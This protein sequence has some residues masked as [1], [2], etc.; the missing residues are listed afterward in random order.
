[1]RH[2]NPWLLPVL[3]RLDDMAYMTSKLLHWIF[4]R[5]SNQPLLPPPDH[6]KPRKKPR[7]LVHRALHKVRRKKVDQI[8]EPCPGIYEVLDFLKAH[9]IPIAMVSNGLGKGYGHDILKT[10]DLEEYFSAIIFREDISKSKPN[11]ESLSAAIKKL[12]V[13]TNADT[14]IWYIGDRRKDVLAACALDE[15]I[16]ASVTPIAYGMNA[17]LAIM[18]QNIGADHIFPSYY[19][20]HARLEKF[21]GKT[22][23]PKKAKKTA[24]KTKAKRAN[25]V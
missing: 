25:A 24:T 3:E 13:E 1:M 12:G 17:A 14:N 5:K 7:L 18:Q 19:D 9:D 2:I 8:V 16:P 21:L 11:P 4:H 23:A 6:I 15:L 10:F 20:V 22:P